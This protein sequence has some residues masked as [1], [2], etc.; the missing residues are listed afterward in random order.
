MCRENPRNSNSPSHWA[1]TFPCAHRTMLCSRFVFLLAMGTEALPLIPVRRGPKTFAYTSPTSC[2]QGLSVMEPG[3]K[4]QKPPGCITSQSQTC[5]PGNC[6][7]L[8]PLNHGFLSFPSLSGLS[9]PS[10]HLGQDFGVITCVPSIY[11][12]LSTYAPFPRIDCLPWMLSLSFHASLTSQNL[13][14]MC[15]QTLHFHFSTSI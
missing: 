15:L 14:Q 4:P 9:V 5:I 6:S 10:R 2:S 13:I 1:A 7:Y 3:S 11:L 12:L 8:L